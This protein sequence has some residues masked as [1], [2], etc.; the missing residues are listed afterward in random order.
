MFAIIKKYQ[1]ELESIQGKVTLFVSKKHIKRIIFR[2][3][4]TLGG[5]KV[6]APVMTN[7]K[8]I[9]ALFYEKERQILALRARKNLPAQENY[10]Y[11]GKLYDSYQAILDAPA[12][13]NTEE[14]NQL[15]RPTFL[16]YLKERTAFFEQLMKIPIEHK[17]RVRLMKTRWGT[18]SLHTRT[19]TYNLSLLHYHPDIIDAIVVHELAHYFIGGHQA[20]FYRLVTQYIPNYKELAKNLKRGNYANLHNH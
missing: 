18:N 9:T 6:S 4:A 15:I 14:F 10:Y 2:Y 12:S 8:E 1:L 16:I 17:V 20:D 7:K 13:L 5:F 19:I 11:L 3:D